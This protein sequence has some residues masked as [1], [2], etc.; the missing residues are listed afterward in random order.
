MITGKTSRLKEPVSEFT[1]SAN[2]GVGFLSYD[3]EFVGKTRSQSNTIVEKVRDQAEKGFKRFVV[4][5]W[6]AK[7]AG[8]DDPLFFKKPLSTGV[9]GFGED[10]AFIRLEIDSKGR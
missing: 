2:F 10:L 9:K 7:N 5:V 6:V 4:A 8:G 3:V 1:S